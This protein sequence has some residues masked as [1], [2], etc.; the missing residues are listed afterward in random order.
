MTKT[1][2]LIYLNEA[3]KPVKFQIPDVSGQVQ[4]ETVRNAMST[5]LDLNVL[6]PASGKIAAIK[7]AQIIEKETHIIF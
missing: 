6:N 7:G 5:L 4:E 3:H 1:L 2:E